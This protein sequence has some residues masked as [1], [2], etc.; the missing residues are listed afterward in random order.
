MIDWIGK[1]QM[2]YDLYKLKLARQQQNHA[3]EATGIQE[4]TNKLSMFTV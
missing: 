4:I 1:I 3:K 2:N